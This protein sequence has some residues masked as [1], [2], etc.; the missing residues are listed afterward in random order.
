MGPTFRYSIAVVTMALVMGTWG[1]CGLAQSKPAPAEPFERLQSEKTA[2][3]AAAQTNYNSAQA[4]D[5]LA[6][7]VYGTFKVEQ[8]FFVDR[9]AVRVF[10]P[11]LQ[12]TPDGRLTYTWS[13]AYHQIAA[14][15]PSY[16]RVY[17]QRPDQTG[18][19][20]ANQCDT[21]LP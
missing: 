20:C 18:V 8:T 14:E 4:S 17:P 6:A 10:W 1:P 3:E 11:T 19:A 16:P 21:K 2:D 13:G 9:G 5:M 15:Y 7:G 12:S